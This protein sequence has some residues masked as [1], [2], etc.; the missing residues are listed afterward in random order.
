MN[1][2]GSGMDMPVKCSVSGLCV[3]ST[4]LP[5]SMTRATDRFAMSDAFRQ[6]DMLWNSRVDGV[7]VVFER[8]HIATWWGMIFSW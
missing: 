8:W 7:C 2:G 1:H 4:A 5:A 3:A 6:M